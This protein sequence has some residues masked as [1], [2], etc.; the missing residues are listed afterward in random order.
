MSIAAVFFHQFRFLVSHGSNMKNAHKANELSNNSMKY[1]DILTE[2]NSYW[3]ILVLH[4]F[5]V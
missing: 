4:I 5:L 2:S 3:D 1:D